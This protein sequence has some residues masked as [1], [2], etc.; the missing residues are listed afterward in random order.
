MKL[1]P[2]ISIILVVSLI[3][4]ATVT[5][6]FVF[7][8][9]N[10]IDKSYDQHYL[11]KI[12]FEI[13]QTINCQN[14]LD[15]IHIKNILLKKKNENNDLNFDLFHY[16]EEYYFSTLEINETKIIKEFNKHKENF[17]KNLKDKKM[18]VKFI[19]YFDITDYSFLGPI[20]IKDKHIG[21]IVVSVKENKFFPLSI[22]INRERIL[23]L[24]ITLFTIFFLVVIISYFI[25]FILTIPMINRL[26][27]IFNRL[28]NFHPEI[29]NLKIGD[30]INDEI[31]VIANTFDS[32]SEKINQYNTD[33]KKYYTERQQIFSEISH[34]FRTPLTAILGY[35][36]FLDEDLY[37]SKEEAK[38]YYKNIRKRAEYMSKLFEEFIELSR[39]DSDVLILK[40]NNFD[41]AE[42]VR[43]IIIEYIP[44]LEENDF[45]YEVNIQDSLIYNGDK[46]RVSRAIRNIIDNV[47]R[48]GCIGKYLGIS[49]F[50]KEHNVNIY[51]KDKGS[52]IN[53]ETLDKIFSR[54]YKGTSKGGMGLGLSIA[55]GIIEKH[56]GRILVDSV[57]NQGTSFTIILPLISDS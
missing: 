10:F 51:I 49:V 27:I 42:L 3:V 33:Q 40:R 44:Q 21:D 4:S 5:C 41:I 23:F 20:I 17:E 39:L 2:K 16:D 57:L 31:G 37:E 52:G 43:E 55:K 1:R 19:N 22:K 50:E 6:I 35:A 30:K 47:F 18:N 53:S 13:I 28:K 32:M 11:E 45:K 25:I 8:M 9:I 26:K 48:H 34:D 15:S 56:H 38:V 54:F 12:Y 29:E 36:T 14:E 24:Y 7:F 46:D